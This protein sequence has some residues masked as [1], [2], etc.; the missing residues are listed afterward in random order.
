VETEVC[1]DK[2]MVQ[3]KSDEV[4][5][6]VTMREKAGK[7]TGV[8]V[9]SSPLPASPY[10]LEWEDFLVWLQGGTAVRVTPRDGMEAVRM[11]AAALKSAQSGRPVKV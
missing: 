11:A 3:F 8:L 6:S 5:M 2:G 4:P 1:G 10:Q 9:P 7:Q